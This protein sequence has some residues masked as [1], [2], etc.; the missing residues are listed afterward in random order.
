[1]RFSWDLTILFLRIRTGIHLSKGVEGFQG[2]IQLA[3]GASKKKKYEK[4]A[5]L[6]LLPQV[7]SQTT[8]PY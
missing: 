7:A 4:V 8:E 1:M 6:G 5:S 3:L 2:N